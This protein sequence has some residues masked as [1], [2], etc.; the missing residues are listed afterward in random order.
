MGRRVTVRSRRMERPR[1]QCRA[2]RQGSVAAA[3]V[4]A[5]LGTRAPGI[6]GRARRVKVAGPKAGRR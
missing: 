3:A 2:Q 1:A 4:L 6:A 5:P